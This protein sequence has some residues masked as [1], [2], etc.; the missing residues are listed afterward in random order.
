[1]RDGDKDFLFGYIEDTDGLEKK[2]LFVSSG[3][4]RR[5]YAHPSRDSAK[6]EAMTQERREKE[7]NLTA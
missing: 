4:R 3:K 7:Q 5:N 1:M 6:Q 2:G